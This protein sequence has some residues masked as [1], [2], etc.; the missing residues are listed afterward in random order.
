MKV[1]ANA[2]G[3]NEK[4]RNFEF[5]DRDPCSAKESRRDS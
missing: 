2:N 5:I 1:T 4:T 3:K